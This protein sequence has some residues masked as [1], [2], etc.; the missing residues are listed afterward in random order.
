MADT[1]DVV[2]GSSV[3]ITVQ[4]V[5]VSQIYDAVSRLTTDTQDDGRVRW[6]ILGDVPV[7]TLYVYRNGDYLAINDDVYGYDEVFVNVP[8]KEEDWDDP[9]DNNWDDDWDNWDDGAEDYCISGY[10]EDDN[11]F[12]MACKKGDELLVKPFPSYIVLREKEESERVSAAAS[13]DNLGGAQNGGVSRGLYADL[14]LNNGE[15]YDT[16]D[17]DLYDGTVAASDNP[18]RSA[19]SELYNGDGRH[20]FYMSSGSGNYQ[21][22]VAYLTYDPSTFFATPYWIIEF[23]KFMDQKFSTEEY[24]I[25]GVGSAVDVN[26]DMYHN[27]QYDSEI[28]GTGDDGVYTADPNWE[29]SY[30]E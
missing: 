6:M 4:N 11:V 14:M 9:F 26:N 2:V 16:F 10:G 12:Y 3:D 22:E 30:N 27:G 13:R 17:I 29:P 7:K 5:G 23:E 28:Y 19:E 21:G 20:L 1:T 8:V 24:V 25:S 15:V 18:R